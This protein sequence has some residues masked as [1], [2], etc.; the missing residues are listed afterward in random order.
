MIIVNAL[1]AVT[2][3]DNFNDQHS[4]CNNYN[5]CNMGQ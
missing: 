3:A 1:Q 5:T 4:S 2:Q